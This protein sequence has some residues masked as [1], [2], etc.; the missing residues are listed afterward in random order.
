MNYRHS[1][2]AGNFADVLKHAVLARILSYLAQ[3]PAPFRVID[4]HA[5]AG[6]YD[7]AGDEASRTGEWREGVAR[8]RAARLD[9]PAEAMLA[10]YRAVLEGLAPEESSYP[11][12][13]AIIQYELREA[14]RASLNE[15]HEDTFTDLK[16]NMGRDERLAVNRLDGYTAWKAQIPPPERRGLVVVDPPFEATNEFDRLAT[17]AEIM[18]RKWPNGL[19]LFWYPVKNL[20]A[21]ARFEA[22]L[23]ETA[24][25]KILIAELHVADVMAEGPLAACGLALINPPY[26]LQDELAALL[27]QLCT[28]L[29][30]GQQARWRLDWLKGE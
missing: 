8:L 23:K 10:P 28:L 30:R 15:L 6:F 27:P 13:P 14:D 19:G 4:T 26:T 3:K 16:A 11:G 22:R 24:L 9:E 17:G 7:L 20:P 1:F 18:G 5:G 2:H 29:A 21:V 25:P 12:S